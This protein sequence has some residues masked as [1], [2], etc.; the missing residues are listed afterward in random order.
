MH[1]NNKNIICYS[2]HEYEPVCP[3][4]D[5]VPLPPQS[6]LVV[7]PVNQGTSSLSE[8]FQPNESNNDDNLSTAQ[9]LQSELE[10]KYFAQD[11][12]ELKPKVY[13]IAFPFCC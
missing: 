12:T 5:D 4:P 1:F 9:T 3:P 11:Q 2:D 13:S 10:E 8:N 6:V 7:D